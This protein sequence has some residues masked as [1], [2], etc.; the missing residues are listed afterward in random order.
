MSFE[1]REFLRH[2]LA[3]ADFLESITAELTRE[4]LE[5]DP[6]IQRAVVRSTPWRA[7]AIARSTTTSASISTSSGMYCGPRFRR[8][9][10]RSGEFWTRADAT[11]CRTST[12]PAC[13]GR[14]SGQTQR[15]R[16]RLQARHIAGV[17]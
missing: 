9:V 12:P 6:T 8:S 16:I 15:F 13:G 4:Q 11:L 14:T 5:A 3:E 7:C 10:P 17:E 2:M 1:P